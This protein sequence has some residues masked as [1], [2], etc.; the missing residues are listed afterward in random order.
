MNLPDKIRVDMN[1]ITFRELGDALDASGVADLANATGGEQA[2][3]NAAMAWVVL[4]RDY[5]DVT[6][7][8]VLDLP[9][10]ALEVIGSDDPGNLDGATDGATPRPSLAPGESDR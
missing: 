2:R 10:S 3:A 6:L 5:P 4:R 7:D 8:A 9:M 1:E